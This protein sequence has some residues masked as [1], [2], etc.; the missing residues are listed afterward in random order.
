MVQGCG[1]VSTLGNYAEETHSDT[2]HNI[3][4]QYGSTH[5][6]FG[7][8]PGNFLQFVGL[9]ISCLLMNGSCSQ[10]VWATSGTQMLLQ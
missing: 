10:G 8:T 1:L 4:A 6:A 9:W 7:G 2:T 3:I 5:V